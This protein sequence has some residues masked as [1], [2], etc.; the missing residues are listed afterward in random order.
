MRF[1][2]HL[3]Q[4]AHNNSDEARVRESTRMALVCMGLRTIGHDAVIGACPRVL[5]ESN[6]WES[7]REA[8]EHGAQGGLTV[9]PAEALRKGVN[10]C[11]IA[12]K[13]SVGTKNDD[14]YLKR[15]RLLVA[16]EYDDALHDHPKLFKTTFGVHHNIYDI[17]IGHDLMEDFMANRLDRI[18]MLFRDGVEPSDKPVGFFGQKWP[19]RQ[20]LLETAPDWV[21]WDLYD[22]T[23]A[24]PAMPTWEHTR[25]LCRF[26]ACLALR[27]DSPKS[28]LPPL[29][30]MLGLPIVYEPI[31]RNDSPEFNATNTIPLTSWDAVKLA[32]TPLNL[33]SSA[34]NAT[35]DWIN[36]WSPIGQARQIAERFA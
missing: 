11:D 18:R 19:H 14:V 13:C 9:H 7:F 21:E 3:N 32:L 8:Y 34:Y 25:W 30:A 5:M 35:Q 27:G 23:P 6:R 24:H 28:N 36:G 15:C 22:H 20:E 4:C 16:H 33:D 1:V 17:L 31:Q 10:A 26:R 12:F 29:L 2:F